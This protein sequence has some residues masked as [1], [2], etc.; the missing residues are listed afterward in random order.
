M[1][2]AVKRVDL[3]LAIDA[4]GRDVVQIPS[5]G[6]FRPAFD[7][8]VGVVAGAEHRTHGRHPNVTRTAPTPWNVATTVW[9]GFA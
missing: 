7:S 4:D 8:A 6:P 1:V 9:P 2:A 3:V 5:V